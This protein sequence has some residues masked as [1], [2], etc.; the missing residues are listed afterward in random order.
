[1]PEIVEVAR[2]IEAG[3]AER[4][5]I[6]GRDFFE[7]VPVG[8]DVYILKQIIH[9]WNDDP[10]IKIL[11]NCHNAMTDNGSVLVIDGVITPGNAPD[12]NEFAGEMGQT[13]TGI[14]ITKNLP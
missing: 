14:A 5:E 2:E 12:L 11:R 10:S 8:G 3:V 13:L 6:I 4:C 7:S 9:T 1:M